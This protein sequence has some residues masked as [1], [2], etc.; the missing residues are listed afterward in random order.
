MRGWAVLIVLLAVALPGCASKND[1]PSPAQVA[2]MVDRSHGAITGHVM[3]AHGRNFSALQVTLFIV[4]T[5]EM[6]SQTETTTHGMFYFQR[7]FPMQYKV[8]VNLK[9]WPDCYLNVQA[10]RFSNL[11]LSQPLYTASGTKGG[12]ETHA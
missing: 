3:D 10:A 1:E 5:K 2:H 11:T 9:D 8:Q 4:S 6:Y 7:L 12:C